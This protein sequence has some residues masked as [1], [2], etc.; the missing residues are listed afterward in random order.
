MLRCPC[1]ALHRCLADRARQDHLCE[2]HVGRRSTNNL[3]LNCQ[4]DNCT[5]KTVKRDHIT[6]HIRVHVPMKPH[7]CRHCGKTFK[8]PQDLKKHEKTHAEDS[9]AAASSSN[10]PGG[11]QNGFGGGVG[12]GH[13]GESKSSFLG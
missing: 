10:Q 7:R 11:G 8:R 13:G 6:S 1:R 12:G 3:T 9:S 5:G 2:K 4:W